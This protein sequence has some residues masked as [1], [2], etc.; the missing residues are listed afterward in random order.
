[1]KASKRESEFVPRENYT[2]RSEFQYFLD[3]NIVQKTEAPTIAM[4]VFLNCAP[5]EL[6]PLATGR[7]CLADVELI[8]PDVFK[9][10][11]GL[12]T[13]H[14]VGYLVNNDDYWTMLFFPK[15]TDLGATDILS[16]WSH[17]M[18][19]RVAPSYVTYLQMIDV[20]ESLGTLEDS[21]T[22]IKEYFSRSLKGEGTIKHWP[23]NVPFSKDTVKRQARKDGAIVD[24]LK[25]LFYTRDIKFE[26][27]LSRRGP[28]TFYGGT[29]SEFQRLVMPPIIKWARSNLD[30]LHARKREYVGE[31]VVVQPVKISTEASLTKEDMDRLRKGVEQH[32][33]TA[34]L[35]GGNPWLMLSLVDKSDGSTFDLQAYHDEIIIAPVLRVS[36]ESLALLYS[37]LEE[38]LPLKIPQLA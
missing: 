35:Y 2:N 9:L 13:R 22:I 10:D 24:Q 18:F 16:R 31:S 3:K 12:K 34:V 21:K 14:L 28:I 30:R 38:A 7:D 29:F 20:V 27:K 36:A 32:Y 6:P 19:P 5:E 11:I 8:I 17:H 15:R 33:M 25:F 4:P 37:I 23:K 26:A 1:M